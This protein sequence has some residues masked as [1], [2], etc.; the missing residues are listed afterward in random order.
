MDSY[1]FGSD[2]P[3]IEMAEALAK[4]ENKNFK[5]AYIRAVQNFDEHLSNLTYSKMDNHSKSYFL[6]HILPNVITSFNSIRER[7]RGKKGAFHMNYACGKAITH[8]R[9]KINQRRNLFNK[10]TFE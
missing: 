1:C 6:E 10:E 9:F 5:K 3:A 4:F 8:F 2:S 7:Y